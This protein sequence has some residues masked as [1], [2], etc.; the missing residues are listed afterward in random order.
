MTLPDANLVEA[1][2]WFVVAAGLLAAS[3]R[4]A[5]H[6]RLDAI[7]AALFA[8]FGASDLVEMRT[9]AWYQPLWLFGWKSLNVAGIFAFLWR[10]TH[11]V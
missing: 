2:V 8:A 3:I 7:G 9:G 10:R 5:S 6:R 11:D 1:C 4:G